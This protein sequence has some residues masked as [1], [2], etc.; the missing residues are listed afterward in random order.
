MPTGTPTAKDLLEG[1]VSPVQTNG[2]VEAAEEE[3]VELGE[4]AEQE[5]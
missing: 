4:T 2:L 3:V 5:E 1:K